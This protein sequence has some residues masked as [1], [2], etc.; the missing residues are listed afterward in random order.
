MVEIIPAINAKT[1]EEAKE[2][3]RRVEHFV[4]W[5]HLDIADGTFT[6]NTLWH[7]ALDLVGFETVAKLEVHLMQDHP[8]DRFEAWLLPF[9]KRIIVHEEVTHDFHFI[10]DE[11]HKDKV[12]AGIAIATDTSWTRLKSFIGKADMLQVLAVHSGLAGQE[13]QAHN[14]AKIKHLRALCPHCKIEV[15]GGVKIGV[16]RHAVEMGADML[17]AASSIF[18]SSDIGQAIRILENDVNAALK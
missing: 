4:K 14:Y 17:V 10:R 18:S 1:W 15:D 9:V 16:A 8:E 12:E 11:C 13:F 6:K 2:K 5:I 3:I 7:N